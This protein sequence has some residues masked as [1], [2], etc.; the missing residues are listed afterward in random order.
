MRE[1]VGG[2]WIVGLVI[3]FMLLFV[4]YLTIMINYSS[5]FKTKNEV[6]QIIEKYEGLSTNVGGSVDIINNYL[7][8]SGYSAT[9][10]CDNNWYGIT[11]LTRARFTKNANN[12]FYCVKR[13]DLTR[14][15]DIES[16]YFDIQLFIQ[17]DLPIL[18][19]IGQFRVKGQTIKIN[20]INYKD[21]K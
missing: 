14:D 5:T 17:F 3:T 19:Q 6:V 16:G 18:G 20:H 2:T 4:S 1:S 11:D 13:S 15:K 12:A 21:V 9:G 7:R 10:K 8:N